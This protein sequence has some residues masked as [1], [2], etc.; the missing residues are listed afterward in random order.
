MHQR[1]PLGAAPGRQDRDRVRGAG[2]RVRRGRRPRRG[3]A[4]CDSWARTDRRAA[5][6]VAGPAPAPVRPGGPGSRVP[7]RHLHL[8]GR[9]L[10][11]PD[12][13]QARDRAGVLRAGHPGQSRSRAPG[14]G[15]PDLR[16]AHQQQGTPDPGTV[17]H[18]GDHQRGDPQP[19][20]RLQARQDQAVPQ[21]RPGAADRDHHQQHPRL[22]YRQT[23]EQPTRPAG[24]RLLRQPAPAAAP[25]HQPR[26]GHRSRQ[27]AAVTGPVITAAEPASPGCA[28][29]TRRHAL[30]PTADFRLQPAGSPT[31]TCANSPPSCSARPP[32]HRADDLRPAPAAPHGLIERIPRTHRYQ[33]TDT[34]LHHAMFLTR[35]HDRILPAGLAH[36]ADPTAPPARCAPPQAPTRPPS[37][38]SS[39]TPDSPPDHQPATTHPNLTQSSRLRRT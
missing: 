19:A 23:A 34:G 8:A 3:P 4:I 26:P 25:T 22:R 11:D 31:A 32:H 1:Q 30:L 33:V 6:Q 14:P 16:P 29:A 18:P 24:G 35:V 9:V 21:G 39:T 7:L 15:R 28:S 20:R 37:T 12:A 36:L 38:T 27:L 5:A 10:P 17:P 2:Q 13:R